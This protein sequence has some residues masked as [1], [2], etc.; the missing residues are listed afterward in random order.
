[1]TRSFG[2]MVGLVL[3]TSSWS[4]A[5][6]ASLYYSDGPW[7][8]TVIDAETKEPI[9]G[10]VVVAVW[11]KVYATPA[12]DNS[13]F[14]DAIETL[15]DK[16][17]KFIVPKFSAINVIPIIRRIE[18]PDFTIFKPGYTPFPGPAYNYFHKYFSNSPLRV[19]RKARM[20]LFKK[21]VIVELLRLKSNE[22][23]RI[24]MPS[25]IGDISYYKKQKQLIKLIN[26]ERKYLGFEGEYKSEE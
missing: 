25:P 4:L 13:Y 14:F 21:G 24:N 16:D 26:E 2:L 6:S 17:G 8:G 1:M 18:G 3:L 7:K 19:D 11:Q 20:E 15:T 10:A 22:E 9:E 12:G 5:G 23:R